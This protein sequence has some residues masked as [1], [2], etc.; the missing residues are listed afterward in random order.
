MRRAKL[1]YFLGCL[2]LGAIGFAIGLTYISEKWPGSGGRETLTLRVFFFQAEVVEMK[3][4]KS[5]W[6]QPEDWGT[7][8]D[9]PKATLEIEL[10]EPH[11]GDL[12]L[13]IIFRHFVAS[14]TQSRRV[15]ISVNGT[16]TDIW[17]LDPSKQEWLKRVRI[18]KKIWDARRPAEITFFFSDLKSPVE[19]GIGKDTRRLAI[20]LKT[21]TIRDLF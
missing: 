10:A 15:E 11:S 6:S 3:V 14:K 5:G 2:V 21:L 16:K 20:G 1:F 8:S 19:L 7:W 9:G 17:M 18:Q 13:E 12:D 4:L